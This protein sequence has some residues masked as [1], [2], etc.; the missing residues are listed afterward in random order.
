M[1]GGA[2]R[3][4]FQPRNFSAIRS[5]AAVVCCSLRCEYRFTIVDL[6]IYLLVL[7]SALTIVLTLSEE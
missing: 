5:T 2:R 7:G 6:G 3:C 1:L 4:R